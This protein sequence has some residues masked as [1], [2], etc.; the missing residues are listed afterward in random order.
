MNGFFNCHIDLSKIT[1]N[2]AEPNIFYQKILNFFF[3]KKKK[4]VEVA[5]GATKLKHGKGLDMDMS[6]VKKQTYNNLYDDLGLAK[7]SQQNESKTKD[8]K[9]HDELG[10]QNRSVVVQR[11]IPLPKTPRVIYVG[12]LTHH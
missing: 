6:Y 10:Q 9:N 5:T 2:I 12:V 4:K 1:P 3:Q 8:D 11:M 7:R